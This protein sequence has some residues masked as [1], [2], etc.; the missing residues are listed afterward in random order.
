MY[1]GWKTKKALTEWVHDMIHI[2]TV[3]I[4]IIQSFNNCIFSFELLYNIIFLVPYYFICLTLT[5]VPGWD[6][7]TAGCYVNFMLYQTNCIHIEH[8]KQLSRWNYWKVF[9]CTSSMFD[10]Y[11]Y[12]YTFKRKWTI[13]YQTWS[14]DLTK[15]RSY[16]VQYIDQANDHYD[17]DLITIDMI[18]T[19]RTTAV[20]E[21]FVKLM[22]WRRWTDKITPVFQ[23]PQLAADESTKTSWKWVIL[24]EPFPI[25]SHMVNRLHKQNTN[26]PY[27]PVDCTTLWSCNKYCHKTLYQPMRA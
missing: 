6:Y 13:I 14:I 3:H 16:D 1:A 19:E 4:L 11:I 7:S 23:W 24:H 27:H 17:I 12:A 5:L 22:L 25:A 8:L 9:R 15:Y 20:T 26:I 18:L 21:Y 2:S 10:I